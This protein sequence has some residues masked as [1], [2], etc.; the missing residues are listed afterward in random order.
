MEMEAPFDGLLALATTTTIYLE[1][2][3]L[4]NVGQF[5]WS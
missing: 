5:S 3:N 4:S 2:L 1:P